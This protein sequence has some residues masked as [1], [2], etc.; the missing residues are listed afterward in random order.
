MPILRCARSRIISQYFKSGCISSG[1]FSVYM[2]INLRKADVHVSIDNIF[3]GLDLG[4]ILKSELGPISSENDCLS[5][6]AIWGKRTPKSM[7]L[8]FQ[9]CFLIFEDIWEDIG[10]LI[11]S[12]YCIGTFK[13]LAPI[14]EKGLLPTMF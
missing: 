10:V 8:F 4:T 14:P 3:L 5:W 7:K 6:E 1:N 9:I 12:A 11:G 2:A 13:V